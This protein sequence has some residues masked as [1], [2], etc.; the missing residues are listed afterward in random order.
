[1]F[2]FAKRKKTVD[3]NPYIRRLCDLTTPNLTTAIEG[4]SEN[5]YNRRIPTLISPW[6]D[7]RPLVDECVIGLTTDMAD[8]GVCLVLNQPFHA[9]AVVVGYWISRDAMCEPWFFVGDIRRNQAIGGGFWAVGIELA[10]FANPN[11]VE[12]L[13]VLK[14]LTAKLRSPADHP[15]QRP[16]V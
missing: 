4:R 9:D 8:R 3:L 6:Q 11:Y 2:S 16:S 12:T 14:P 1:M 7:D 10:E 15:A 13:A 5:R